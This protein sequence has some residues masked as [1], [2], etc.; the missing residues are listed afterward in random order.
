MSSH[1]MISMYEREIIDQV[2][3][4]DDTISKYICRKRPYYARQKQDGV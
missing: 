4:N 3:N 2:H 1:F